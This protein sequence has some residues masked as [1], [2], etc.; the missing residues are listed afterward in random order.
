MSY[1]ADL[2]ASRL[3]TEDKVG[4]QRSCIEELIGVKQ[5]AA[6]PEVR[7]NGRPRVERAQ[8]K[9]RHGEKD[10][11]QGQAA[12]PPQAPAVTVMIMI[13]PHS[14]QD[15]NLPQMLVEFKWKRD[16]PHILNTFIGAHMHWERGEG[17]TVHAV[18][19]KHPAETETE[20]M[21][22][23]ITFLPSRTS[24][25]VR[26]VSSIDGSDVGPK[27]VVLKFNSD[28]CRVLLERQKSWL[29]TTHSLSRPPPSPADKTKQALV[30]PWRNSN[31]PGMSITPC[32]VVLAVTQSDIGQ[33]TDSPIPWSSMTTLALLEEVVSEFGMAPPRKIL[34]ALCALSSLPELSRF[35]PAI[36]FEEALH[37]D[38]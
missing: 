2:A 5:S 17:R 38:I 8:Q 16:S 31:P 6:G 35:F 1:W 33:P 20:W 24:W 25:L 30:H 27:P 13:W 4:T 34:S 19:F 29:S 37:R 12:L 32:L 10:K 21:Q 15:L 18:F 3:A 14:D 9:I 23:H 7:L 26:H 28:G 36:L 11:D 22:T